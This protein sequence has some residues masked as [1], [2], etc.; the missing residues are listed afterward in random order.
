MG[1]QVVTQMAVYN[2]AEL[3]THHFRVGP[4]GVIVPGAQ[5]DLILVDYHPFTPLSA[6][7]LPWH[8]L[9]GFRES[10]VTMTMVAGKLLMRNRELLTLDEDKIVHD[11][12][13]AASS[14]WKN[15]QK[16]F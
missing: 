11:A 2:N 3:A 6:G 16:L 7:N 5:A 1:G 15:Y 10:M 9:F 8:I 12:A 14:T 13:Q 4:I